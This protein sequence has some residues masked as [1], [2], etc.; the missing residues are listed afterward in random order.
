MTLQAVVAVAL[1]A[2]LDLLFG[3]PPDRLHPVAWLGTSIGWL[4]RD[5]LVPRIAGVLLALS[6][7]FFV[8]ILVA[9]GLILL[10]VV[11]PWV[12]AV[13][14]GLVLYTTT[15]LRMLCDRA[16]SVLA[17]STSDPDAARS[18]VPALVG[19][20]PESLSPAELRSAAVESAAENL[21]DGLVAP[22][23]AFAVVIPVSLP[24]AAGAAAWV[25]AVNT[26]D[27]MVGYP[28][29]PLGTASARLDDIVMWLP[30]RITALLLVVVTRTPAALARARRWAG[31]P[32]SPNAGWPMATLAAIL[33]VRLSK[34]GVYDLNPNA[35]FPSTELGQEGIRIVTRAG[36]LAFGLTGVIAWL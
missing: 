19:R 23:V 7:P 28:E 5:W 27:S 8:A 14:A 24:L 13:S 35:P 17:S 31:E 4:D 26:L 15:S 25:K 12:A 2:G 18:T 6:V 30:A 9:N 33:D 22:L 10:Q 3:E 29:H 34:P 32:P 1:A 11:D 21:S 36:R 16:Q 20:D